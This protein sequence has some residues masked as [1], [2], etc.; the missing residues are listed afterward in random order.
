MFFDLPEESSHSP[1]F[2]SMPS[3]TTDKHTLGFF[4]TTPSKR[5]PPAR[6]ELFLQASEPA[7]RGLENEGIYLFD[8]NGSV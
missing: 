2:P 8:K 5:K 4:H 7:S 3:Y 1:V 6:V